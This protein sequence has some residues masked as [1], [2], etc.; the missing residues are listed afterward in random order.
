MGWGVGEGVSAPDIH[1]IAARHV[2]GLPHNWQSR[3][4]LSLDRG[5]GFELRGGC[6][7]IATAEQSRIDLT[8]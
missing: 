4:Y 8:P 5:L 2:H 7:S 3:I 1:T 6:W